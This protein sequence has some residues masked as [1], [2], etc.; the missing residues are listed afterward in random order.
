MFVKEWE[1]LVVDDDEDV[2]Q[3]TSLALKNVRIAGAPLKIHTARSKAEA[4]KLINSQL[5]PKGGFSS[6]HVALIDVVMET[7]TAG[8]ELCQALRAADINK[9]TQ[10]YIRTGQPGLAPEREVIDRYEIN[11]Y[12]S[13]AEMTED[14]LYSMVTAGVRQAS[15][16]AVSAVLSRLQSL[17]IETNHS[18]EAMK[19]VLNGIIQ[20]LET[21]ADGKTIDS[22]RFD[23][24]FMEGDNVIAGREAAA[25][26]K[27]RLQKLPGV[28]MGDKGDR[29][30]IDGTQ[31]L[32]HVPASATTSEFFFAVD[33]SS[34][35]RLTTLPLYQNFIR[36]L[37]ALWKQ[38]SP[39][40]QTAL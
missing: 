21:R 15:Y 19:M 37:A 25:A 30:I 10:I 33:S 27:T 17:L 39:E 40:L 7:N 13:K 34:E 38:S 4:L 18:K 1:I 20:T 32:I 36:S 9:Y 14:K 12:F 5:L 26:V 6:I 3:I 23:M 31:L 24:A 35:V 29:Y 22:V 8:L 2:L 16:M 11:G 28:A